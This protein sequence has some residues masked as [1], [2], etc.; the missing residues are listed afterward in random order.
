MRKT[1][2]SISAAVM[3]GLS[4]S[5][6]AALPADVPNERTQFAKADMVFVGTV[7]RV[8]YRMSG[9]KGDEQRI[10]HTFVTY[11]VEKVLQGKADDKQVTLRFIGGRGEKSA[12]LSVSN[13]PMFDAGDRDLLMVA[14]NG[15]A[16]CP[17]V[18]CANGRYRM[19]QG[20]VFSEAGQAIEQDSKGE[21][22]R[23]GFYN[24]PEVMT[25]KVSQTTLTLEDHFEQ[26]EERVDFDDASRGAHL[27]E[28]QIV[29][30]IENVARSFG[31]AT[32]GEFKSADVNA[33]FSIEFDVAD[34]PKDTAIKAPVA[35]GQNAQERAEAAAMRANGGNPA[36]GEFKGEK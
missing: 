1:L 11:N 21:L 33:A 23:V 8:E 14:D 15:T 29:A 30:R 12:F 17:L 31:K 28:A 27:D 7:D 2:S 24:L 35:K 34:A 26:G 32:P 3:L 25:T 19:I 5:A 9:E 36:I 22:T 16:G 4:A 20:K 6:F 18:S 10:P 13:Q